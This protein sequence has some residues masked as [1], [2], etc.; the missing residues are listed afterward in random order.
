MLDGLDT[1]KVTEQGTAAIAPVLI[2]GSPKLKRLYMRPTDYENT[3]YSSV[4]YKLLRAVG[5]EPEDE[6]TAGFGVLCW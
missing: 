4:I 3:I 5:R 2:N 1:S 6:M